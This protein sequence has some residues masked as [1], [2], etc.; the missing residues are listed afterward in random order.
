MAC[1]SPL[2]SV[3]CRQ[4]IG[5]ASRRTRA[6][7]AFVTIFSKPGLQF[8]E[9]VYRR[10]RTESYRQKPKS[11]T[12]KKKVQETHTCEVTVFAMVVFFSPHFWTTRVYREPG[13][14][15][16]FPFFLENLLKE[17]EFIVYF[18]WMGVLPTCK[19]ALHPSESG[20]TDACELPWVLG[21]EL[22]SLPA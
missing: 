14:C 17:D 6:F 12:R 19:T 10:N 20:A 21:F 3:F 11:Q 18:M 16:F 13:I 4:R 1:A 8:Q 9:A 7:G 15:L 2:T 22:C 5:A